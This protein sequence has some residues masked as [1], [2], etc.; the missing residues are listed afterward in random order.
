VHVDDPAAPRPEDAVEFGEHGAG[1]HLGAHRDE[2]AS[3]GSGD[4]VA[5]RD[6]HGAERRRAG[7]CLSL[8]RGD[9]GG[10]GERRVGSRLAGRHLGARG[11]DP[12]PGQAQLHAAPAGDDLAEG[13]PGKHG[14]VLGDGRERCRAPGARGARIGGGDAAQ[15]AAVQR[16]GEAEPAV[17]LRRERQ[18]GAVGADGGELDRHVTVLEPDGAAEPAAI[19]GELELAAQRAGGAAAEEHGPAPFDLGGR[20]ECGGG[21]QQEEGGAKAEG[22]KDGR[23]P[24]P[25][26]RPSALPP[27]H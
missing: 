24:C 23:V 7:E 10:P 21:Q 15:R 4:F 19:A 13:E 16:A 9:P 12:G 27:F 2:R 25:S 17:G 8:E 14:I 18:G 26:F 6:A 5:P 22:R 20:G 1:R 11:G 3:R